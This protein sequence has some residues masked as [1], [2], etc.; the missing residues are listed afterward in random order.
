LQGRDADPARAQ[1]SVIASPLADKK[2]TKKSLK[3]V[4]KGA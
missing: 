1:I 3:V 2:L 4:K